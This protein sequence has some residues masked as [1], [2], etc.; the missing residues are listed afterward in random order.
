[1]ESKRYIVRLASLLTLTTI[2]G[3]IVFAGRV[4]ADTFAGGD[5]SSGS[6]YQIATCAQLQAVDAADLSAYYTL[7]AD[8]NCAATNPADDSYDSGGQWGDGKG[9]NPIG[10]VDH[11]FTG[12]FDGANHAISGLFISRA[13]DV[14]GQGESDEEYVGLFAYAN[15][16]NIQR[17]TLNDA[18]VKGYRYVGGI[19]GYSTNTALTQLHVNDSVADNSCSPGFCVWARWGE[20][21]GGIVGYMNAGYMSN[22][23]SGGNVKG[24]GQKIG[25]LIG[26]LNNNYVQNSHSTAHVDGGYVVGGIVG[27]LVNATLNTVYSSGNIDVV[28]ED[29]KT[30]NQGGGLVGTMDGSV[31]VNSY[32]T[33]NINANSVGGGL[34]G[35]ANVSSIDTSYTT[36]D[37]SV[38]YYGGGGIIGTA[39]QSD[40]TDSY[41]T[42]D[43]TGYLS[44]GGLVGESQ[45]ESSYAD[46]YA[47]GAV[48]GYQYIGG[49]AGYDGCEG[50]GASFLNTYATG[51]VTGSYSVGG[52]LGESWGS[53]IVQ[54]YA[55]GAVSGEQYV[56][57]LVGYN[58][59]S[60]I[61][62]SFATGS[63]TGTNYNVGGLIGYAD[64][65]YMLD[66]Y[67]SG[68]VS[69]GGGIVGGLLGSFYGGS[70]RQAY[71]SGSV[72]ITGEEGQNAG[73]LIGES[74]NDTSAVM[75]S[76]TFAVGKVS[77]YGNHGGL[78]ANLNTDSMEFSNNY[79]D[80]YGTGQTQC[81]AVVVEVIGCNGVNEAN[82]Q[83]RYF[84]S[85]VFNNPLDSWDMEGT[86]WWAH[87]A[88]H[89]PCLQ[90]YDGCT[91]AVGE[92]DGPG[93]IADITS[94]EDDTP[95]H[96]TADSCEY[97]SVPTST[98]ES[99]LEVQDAV[100]SYPKGLVNFT[101]NNC[102][103][104]AT[105][106]VS[107][108]FTGNIDLSG[109]VGR[110]Y[111][112]ANHSYTSI[113]GAII[114]H[115]T[116]NGQPATRVTYQ[117]TDGGVL[118]QDGQANGT[119][120]DP[121]GI[122]YSPI[123][124]PNTGLGHSL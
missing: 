41:A 48:E 104:G 17:T 5:G 109:L 67:A 96:L 55:A 44:V 76:N 43:V 42:G 95:V 22:S 1:M 7:T 86:W 119:I 32:A 103:Q 27:E 9:F 88:P 110:K 29:H 30:G 2:I 50:P 90:W 79:F 100:F 33:G 49:F 46:S 93:P 120:V 25:G 18:M 91:A 102:A 39:Y 65:A 73:G 112:S 10:D 6:P 56:G 84:T 74:Y 47:T 113:S 115:T 36:G 72:T 82:T 37:V 81:T 15:E 97:F 45:C 89:Y 66:V 105:V 117:I 98:K 78:V 40:V 61:T 54:S 62:R 24:S 116:L 3:L 4:Q 35:Y 92:T 21:G 80:I 31:I 8:I 107:L 71:A 58:Y 60:T 122:G 77:G 20:Y 52:F 53:G 106:T 75:I 59:G 34:V 99:D 38:N 14:Y 111:N 12:H 68:N 16:A 63:A 51:S 26:H 13:D 28:E 108:T 123:G 69:S 70:L 23:S 124:A 64:T 118:D 121:A 19:V 85:G 101:L 11:A 94:A 114:D 83:S 57:G 87:N